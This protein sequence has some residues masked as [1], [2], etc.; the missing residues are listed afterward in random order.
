MGRYIGP[1]CRLCRRE[2]MKLCDKHKC[3]TLKRNFPPGMHGQ[4]RQGKQ[5]DYAKQLREK[6]KT[7]RIF[8]VSEK[9]LQ[10]YYAKAVS[11]KEESGSELLRQ[12]ERRLDNIVFRC[13]FASSRRQAR[14]MVSHGLFR[15]NGKRINVPSAQLEEGDNLE[16]RPRTKTSPLFAEFSKKKLQTPKWLKV[17]SATLTGQVTGK[18][19]KDDLESSVAPH[20]IIEFYS[21]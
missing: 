4:K 15:L 18:P 3:A 21:R 2:G 12:L 16:V 1:I 20:M 11:S 10:K 7:R 5:S 9:Q 13:G 14:Q 8:G 6:Q 19:E 17:D